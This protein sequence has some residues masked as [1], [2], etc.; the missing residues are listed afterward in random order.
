LLSDT[1]SSHGFGRSNVR[2]SE[3]ELTIQVGHFDVVVISDN[4]F[5]T[6]TAAKT[7]KSE[8]FDVLATEGAST[9]HKRVN[10]AEFI[11][12]FLTIYTNLVVVSAATWFSVRWS[13]WERL[14]HIVVEHLSHRRILASILYN[15]LGNN[16][17][18]K[19]CH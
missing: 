7:H 14:K 17:S 2:F 10:F 18:K 9:D 15:F 8:S 4:D 13:N 12:D 19:S 3:Q 1:A 16:T 11:L 6:L 5:T